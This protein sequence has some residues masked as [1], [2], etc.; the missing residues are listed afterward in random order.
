MQQNHLTLQLRQSCHGGRQLLA[1]QCARRVMLRVRRRRY[2]LERGQ[3]SSCT[4]RLGAA[5]VER[6]VSHNCEQPA[7][8]SIW[9][10]TFVETLERS[11]ERVLRYV[12]RVRWFVGQPERDGVGGAQM[13]P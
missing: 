6:A 5:E 2:V 3:W 10:M 12:L 4:H 1:Q 8:E 13:H 9:I 11:N 7:A